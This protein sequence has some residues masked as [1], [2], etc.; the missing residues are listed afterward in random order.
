[1]AILSTVAVVPSFSVEGLVTREG[2]L[3]NRN[4][5]A[6]AS[7]ARNTMLFTRSNVLVTPLSAFV[8]RARRESK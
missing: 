8:G 6:I 7:R 4:K 3:Q 5:R 1:M 2:A